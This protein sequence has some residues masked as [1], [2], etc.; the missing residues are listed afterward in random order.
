[1]GKDPDVSISVPNY[2]TSDIIGGTL[3][4][5]IETAGDLSVE[6]FVT[7]DCSPDGGLSKVRPAFEHDSR[8]RFIEN[9]KNI[10]LVSHNRLLKEA[11]GRYILLLDSDAILHPGALQSLVSFLDSHSEAGAATARF[12]FPDGRIQRYYR[13]QLTPT[14]YFYTTVIGRFIDKYLLGL[15]YFKR[16]RYD[17]I[18]DPHAPIELEQPSI[19]CFMLRKEAVGP[20]IVHPDMAFHYADVGLCKRIYDHGYK[21]FLVPAAGVTH[22]KSTTFKKAYKRWLTPAH[23]RSLIAYMREAYP[24][25]APLVWVLTWFDRSLRAVLLATIRWEPFV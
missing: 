3:K 4:S 5:I 6:V 15:K 21:V 20:Y 1:M 23:Y 25:Y 24:A 18:G 10:A 8:F 2:N 13:R 19:T 7:N 22:L 17:D 16:Y 14:L 9:E 12:Y 11:K